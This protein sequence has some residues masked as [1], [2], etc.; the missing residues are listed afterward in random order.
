[1]KTLI[2]SLIATSFA[3][4]PAFAADTTAYDKAA[5]KAQADFRTASNKCD[6]LSGN[7][8]DVCREEAKLKRARAELDAAT[9][10]DKDRMSAARRNVIQAEHEVAEEKCEVLQGEAQDDCEDKADDVRDK[11]L[12]KLGDGDMRAVG[13]SAAGQ[14]ATSDDRAAAKAIER[15]EKMTGDDKTACVMDNKGNM[16]AGAAAGAGATL[17][18]R[19]REALHNVKEKTKDA[20]TRADDKAENA[21]DRAGRATS[22]AAIT[23]KVKASLVAEKDLSGMDINVDTEKGVVMLSGFVESKAEADKAVRVAKG[24][25]GVSKVKSTLKVK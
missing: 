23:S 24:V 2:A 17:G 14:T 12:A 21:A 5:S 4:A 8:R 11:A 6:A 1:M 3:V 15:C 20:F 16:T 22:D 25:D 13:A 9:K 18:E 10:H 7:K 19:T